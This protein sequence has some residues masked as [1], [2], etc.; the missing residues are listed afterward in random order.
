MKAIRVEKAGGPEA[1]VLTESEKPRA[2]AGEVLVRLYASGVNFADILCR[3]GSHPGM[4]QPPLVP[5]CEGSGIVE[6][7]GAN[8]TRFRPGDRVSVYSPPGGTYAQWVSL[9]ERYALAVPSSMSFEEAA[10]FTHVF[11]TAYHALSTLG[12]AQEGEWAVVTAA[13]GGVGTAMIQLARVWELRVIAGVGSPEKTA[14]LRELAVDH[15]IDYRTESLARAVSTITRGRGA[16][17][18]LESVGG[19]VFEDAMGCLAPLGRLILF[20][21]ASGEMKEVHPN[22]LLRTSSTFAALNLSVLFAQA[23][24]RVEPSWR[25]LTRLYESGALRPMIRY[26]FPLEKAA[27]AHRLLES[28]RTVGKLLLIPPS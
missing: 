4:P 5:G 1:L 19:R 17:L 16:D 14:F 6:E 8:V 26:R 21:A 7:I 10:A 2:R 11:L 25:E 3:T 23:H 18:V 15:V 9:P 22:E 13:A 20:G 27:E 24:H 28:R 12:G